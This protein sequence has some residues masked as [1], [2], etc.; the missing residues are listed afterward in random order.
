MIRRKAVS[1]AALLA[2]AVALLLSSCGGKEEVV[3][4]DDVKQESQFEGVTEIN[5]GDYEIGKTGGQLVLS[6]ISDPKTLNDAVA[7]EISSTDITYRL[8]T[9]L[10]NRAQQDLEWQPMASESWSFLRRPE[11]YYS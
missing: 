1:M 11:N 9:F 6:V 7:G 3:V 2:V 8:V 5:F 4:E 10:V